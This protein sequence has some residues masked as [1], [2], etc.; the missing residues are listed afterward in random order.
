MLYEVIT[1]FYYD[2]DINENQIKV[3]TIASYWT[4]LAELPN[5]EKLDALTNHLIDPNEFGTDNR[6]NFV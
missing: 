3:K 2:L 6:N 4:L 1:G 5:D